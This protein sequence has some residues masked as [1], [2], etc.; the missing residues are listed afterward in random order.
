M[1][2]KGNYRHFMLKE[3]YEQS[4]TTGRTLSYYIDDFRAKTN[5][6]EE[7]DFSK[8][9]RIIIIACGTA[10]YA[11]MVA[12][13]WFEQIAGIAV[14]IDVASEFRYRKPVPVSYTHLTLPTKA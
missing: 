14:D 9:D 10:F 11:G 4:E 6:P 8:F 2:E 13:Y 1:A 3:I 12:K 5:I 7:L